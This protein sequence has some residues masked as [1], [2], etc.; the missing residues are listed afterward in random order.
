MERYL[1]AEEENDRRNQEQA[2]KAKENSKV[3]ILVAKIE[4]NL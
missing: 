4:R 2:P 1:P 3:T